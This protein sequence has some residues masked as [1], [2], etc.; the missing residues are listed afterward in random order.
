MI[1]GQ[2]VAKREQQTHPCGFGPR[3]SWRNAEPQKLSGER[4]LVEMERAQSVK[5][6]ESPTRQE[7]EERCRYKTMK[8]EHGEVNKGNRGRSPAMT[9][10]GQSRPS[11]CSRRRST[12]EAARS[13]RSVKSSHARATCPSLFLLWFRQTLNI[14]R[15]AVLYRLQGNLIYMLLPLMCVACFDWFNRCA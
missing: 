1:C 9:P 15:V 8:V 3:Y 7:S 5:R 10:D 13:D 14:I 11:N 4:K 12:S 6:Q 2:F